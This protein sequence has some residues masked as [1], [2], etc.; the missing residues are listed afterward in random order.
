MWHGNVLDQVL[1]GPSLKTGARGLC[2]VDQAL[3]PQARPGMSLPDPAPTPQ[4]VQ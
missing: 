4:Y 2:G 1:M 3:G